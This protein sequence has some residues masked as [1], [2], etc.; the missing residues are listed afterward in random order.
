MSI[1]IGLLLFYPRLSVSERLGRIGVGLLATILINLVRLAIIVSMVSLLGKPIVPW[2]HA[3]VG[4]LVFF[5]GILFLYWRMLTL[6]TLTAVRR[7]LEVT[8]RNAL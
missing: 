7:E 3:I 6:P 2:A 4:R 1:F 5:V 8:Q